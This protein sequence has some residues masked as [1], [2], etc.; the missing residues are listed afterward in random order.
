MFKLPSSI[1]KFFAHPFASMKLCSE[2]YLKG[3]MKHETLSEPRASTAIAAHKAESIPPDK[4]KI[5]PGK[6]FLFT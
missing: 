4:P 3:S 6:L 1:F 5:I 2:V